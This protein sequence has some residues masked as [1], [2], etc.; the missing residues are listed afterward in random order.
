MTVDEFNAVPSSAAVSLC[1]TMY[2]RE[3]DMDPPVRRVALWIAANTATFRPASAAHLPSWV[4]GL[5]AVQNPP[6]IPPYATERGP[7]ATWGAFATLDNLMRQI[8]PQCQP[9]DL[10]YVFETYL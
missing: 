4:A 10:Q 3:A 2:G 7:Q 6:P 9:G 5:Q 8:G 1:N